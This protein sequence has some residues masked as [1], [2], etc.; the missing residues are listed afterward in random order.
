MAFI[1]ELTEGDIG[2]PYGKCVWNYCMLKIQLQ[3]TSSSLKTLRT[4]IGFIKA[5]LRA[6]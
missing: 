2:D 1:L 4:H 5:E 6:P 3:N